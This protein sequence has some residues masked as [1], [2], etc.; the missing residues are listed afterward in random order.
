MDAKNL[1]PR[2][3]VVVVIGHVDHGKTTLL[4]YIRKTS[5]ASRE[6]G[7]ITQSIGA[8]EID[9]GGRKITFIDTPGHEAF[10]KMRSAGAEVADLAILVVAAEDG[11]K[12]Q[13]KEAI[14]IL[15]QTKT[16]FVVA[17]NKIDKPEANL[18]KV[19]NDLLTNGV[20]LEGYGGN[21]SYHGISAKTGEGVN[22][23][24]DL[25]LLA[26]D[27]ENLTSDPTASGSGFILEARVDRQRGMETIAIVKNGTLK[28]GDFIGTASVKGKVKILENFLGERVKTLEPSAPALIIGLEKLPHVGEKFETSSKEEFL[29]HAVQEKK[30]SSARKAGG[31]AEKNAQKLFLILKASDAGSL[32]AL[33]ALITGLESA[34]RIAVLREAVGEVNDGDVKLAIAT[35]A[36]IVGFKT[37][38]DQAAKNLAENNRV[39]I[40]TSEIIYDLSK[41]VEEFL[42]APVG[43]EVLGELKVLAVFNKEKTDKQIVGGTVA[44]GVIKN[45]SSFEIVRNGEPAGHGRIL[46]LQEQKK[47]A[48]QVSE[49]SEAGLLVNADA[50]VNVSDSLIIKK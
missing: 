37:R 20:L 46:N 26:A 1:K 29:I 40:I 15:N 18:E 22:D 21:V 48:N 24:L 39:K 4:D 27:V 34:E 38:I 49:G 30:A 9:H 23:L 41:A 45:K 7:G 12:P 2:P 35:G 13:T 17:L 33:V 5:V 44:K 10:T 43:A 42:K 16:P 47:D 36:T 50:F 19:K 31:T 28:A 8:Y 14:E 25:I 32:S 6:A 11:V 3:P